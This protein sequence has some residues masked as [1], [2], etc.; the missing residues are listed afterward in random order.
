[1]NWEGKSLACF[2]GIAPGYTIRFNPSDRQ[3]GFQ[4]LGDNLCIYLGSVTVACPS[5]V[6]GFAMHSGVVCGSKYGHV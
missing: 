4:L 5:V 1:M 2:E 3:D 6:C